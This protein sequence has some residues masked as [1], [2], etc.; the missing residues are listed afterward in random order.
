MLEKGKWKL[1]LNC[2]TGQVAA[3]VYVVPIGASILTH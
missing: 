2:P 3:N 1:N